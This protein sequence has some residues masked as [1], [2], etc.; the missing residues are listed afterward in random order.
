MRALVSALAGLA[1]MMAVPANAQLS[2]LD[3]IGEMKG[4][5]TEMTIAG[6]D[7]TSACKGTLINSGYKDG[8]IGFLFTIGD[9]ALITFSGADTPASGAQ[10]SKSDLDMIIFTR[11]SGPDHPVTS[12]AT[13]ACNYSLARVECRAKADDGGVFHAV[14]VSDGSPPDFKNF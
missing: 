6:H 7:L 8:R 11:M 3:S 9:V 13:G 2:K 1:A 14:F 5:C 10:R 12:K 4:V